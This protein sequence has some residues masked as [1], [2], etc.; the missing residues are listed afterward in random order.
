MKEKTFKLLP[1]ETVLPDDYPIYPGYVYI[2]DGV[3]TRNMSLAENVFQ[4]KNMESK[5]E[6]RRCNLFG[7]KD[8]RL[9][10]RAE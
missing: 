6:V 5:K 7:H 10:D 9:G 8:A 1:D 2:V 3:F 4:W